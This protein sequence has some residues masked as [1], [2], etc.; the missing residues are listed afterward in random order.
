M[1]ET[2]GCNGKD[3]LLHNDSDRLVGMVEIRLTDKA[4]DGAVG[5]IDVGSVS[6]CFITVVVVISGMVVVLNLI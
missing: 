1:S 5:V 3:D 6:G 4:C 2:C